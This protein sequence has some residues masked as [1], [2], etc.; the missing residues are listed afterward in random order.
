MR[1]L[2]KHSRWFFI[3]L[4]YAVINTSSDAAAPAT[5]QITI[6]TTSL[7]K[8]G[9]NFPAELTKIW[10]PIVISQ[11]SKELQI[12]PSIKLIRIDLA[13]EKEFTLPSVNSWIDKLV[14]PDPRVVLKKTF[15]GLEQAKI[16][17]EFSSSLPSDENHLQAHKE[18]YNI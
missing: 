8:E 17:K 2:V 6:L 15:D 3:F 9:D 4:L 16:T 14:K 13:E 18:K 5:L 10:Q 1:Y 11:D 12:A 7:G